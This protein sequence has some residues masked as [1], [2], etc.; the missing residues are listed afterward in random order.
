MGESGVSGREVE[1][2]TGDVKRRLEQAGLNEKERERGIVIVDGFL[3]FGKS[4]PDVRE[5]F[6]LKVMLR[7][8]YKDAKERRE[9]RTGYVTLEGFWEDPPGY[10]D[11]IVWPA[12]KREHGFLFKGSDVEG[13]V[14]DDVVRRLGIEVV[15]GKGHYKME[16]MLLW[17]VELVIKHLATLD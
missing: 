8:S 2:I 14:E 1:E 15:P 6:D 17:V 9:A 3:L 5:A 7:A 13:D 4:V 10:V 11:F 16:D 12:Y